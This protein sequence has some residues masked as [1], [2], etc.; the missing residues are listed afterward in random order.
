MV[1]GEDE[2]HTLWAEAENDIEARKQTIGTS[3]S[4]RNSRSDLSALAR[5][6]PL[7]LEDEEEQ[8][9]RVEVE[10][11]AYAGEHELGVRVED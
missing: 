11:E 4:F 3:S 8:H 6:R 5:A 9:P 7:E 1:R 10:E 2:G